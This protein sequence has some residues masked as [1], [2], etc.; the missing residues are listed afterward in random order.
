M[1]GLGQEELAANTPVL[2]EHVRRH[3]QG[4][5]GSAPNPD[6][7]TFAVLQPPADPSTNAE[8]R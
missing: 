4:I 5:M 6:Q 1:W 2:K 8:E 7:G 3:P